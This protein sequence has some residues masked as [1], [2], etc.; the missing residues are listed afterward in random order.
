MG[1]VSIVPI[2]R[3]TESDLRLLRIFRVVAEVGGITAAETALRMERSTI[4]RHIQALETRLGGRLCLRG[5][6]GF[7]LTEL[8]R[9]ALDAAIIAS[10]TLDQVRDELNG[11]RGLITGELKIGIADNCLSN[12]GA[13]IVSVLSEFRSQAP[14]ATLNVSIRP[15]QELATELLARRLHLAITGWPMGD[16]KLQRHT[17][18]RE[19]FRLYAGAIEGQTVH[20][21][22]LGEHGLRLVT[23]EGER[24]SQALARRL[25]IEGRAVA[26]GLEAVATLLACGGFV[27][28]LP[29][30]YVAALSQMHRFQ[31]V[32]GAEA[33]AYSAEFSLVRERI[34]PL[35]RAGEFF[36]D[37]LIAAHDADAVRE[38]RGRPVAA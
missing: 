29:T 27:G 23:R 7:D 2:H 35:S 9:S 6:S 18:F 3:I 31:E 30:H 34:R 5:P 26:L 21:S 8:G 19:E 10:D 37:L 38:H 15:P 25:G 36:V 11:A 20:L 28:Y 12:P 22:S 24:H 33:V 1:E 14:G 32:A 4:S 16:D 17:L 13:R